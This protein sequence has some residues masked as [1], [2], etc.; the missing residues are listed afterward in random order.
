[1]FVQIK[2]GNH[3]KLKVKNKKKFIRSLLFIIGGS[4]LFTFLI[5]SQSLSHDEIDYKVVYVSQGDT[6]WEIAKQEKQNNTYY[7]DQD[8]RSIIND[9]KQVNQLGN[10]DLKKGQKLLLKEYGK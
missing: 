3:M 10:C 6:L 9:I 7:E 2:G 4:V 1:M 8:I 5:A